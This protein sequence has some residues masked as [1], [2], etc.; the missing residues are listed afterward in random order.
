[1]IE[2]LMVMETQGKKVEVIRKFIGPERKHTANLTVKID[3]V[4]ANLGNI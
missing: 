1:M 2:E 3:G 4:D